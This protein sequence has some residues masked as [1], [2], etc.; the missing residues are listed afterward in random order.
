MPSCAGM[1]GAEYR[2]EETG[3]L[4]EL[5]TAPHVV[6]AKQTRRALAAGQ[7]KTLFLARDADPALTDPLAELAAANGVAVER[8][9]A[10]AQLGAACQIAVGAA[11]CA[12]LI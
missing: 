12:I 10:M 2:R 4:E 7:V 1:A 5:M 11:C 6:G 3:L 9:A 8:E